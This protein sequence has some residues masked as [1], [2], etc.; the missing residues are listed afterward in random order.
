M[1]YT[2]KKNSRKTFIKDM[3]V[4]PLVILPWQTNNITVYDFNKSLSSYDLKTTEDSM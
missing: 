3:D 4:F 1:F 2:K